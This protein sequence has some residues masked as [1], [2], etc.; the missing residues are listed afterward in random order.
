M[1]KFLLPLLLILTSLNAEIKWRYSEDVQFKSYE[2]NPTRLTFL[3]GREAIAGIDED[4]A[5]KIL[6][7]W[8]KGR[9]LV[10]A[11]NKGLGQVIFDPQAQKI[12]PLYYLS[13]KEQII[14]HLMS[15]VHDKAM[16]TIAMKEAG[17]LEIKLWQR[18]VKRQYL[19]IKVKLR[20]KKA[21]NQLSKAQEAWQAHYKAQQNLI[22][23]CLDTQERGTIAGINYRSNLIS[24]LRQHYLQLA[25]Y[26]S[27]Y[28]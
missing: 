8:K 7:T 5:M 6:E 20:K 3:D 24:L 4:N 2:D 15:G 19:A 17:D 23:A 12:F 16:T 14:D 26:R 13:G 10:L 27:D 28:L 25:Q 11:Y 9:K 1:L 22:G 21:R 18:E